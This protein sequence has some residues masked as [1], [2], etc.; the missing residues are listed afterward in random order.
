MTSSPATERNRGFNDAIA[1]APNLKI[2]KALETKNGLAD[3]NNNLPRILNEHPETNIVFAHTDFFG[4]TAYKAAQKAGKVKNLFFVGIDAIPVLTIVVILGA[5]LYF[6]LQEKQ[7]SNRVLEG[8][9]FAILEQ[10]NG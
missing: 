5:F 9:N 3:I 4:V 6:L 2:V 7:H 1:A 8:Q 10:K